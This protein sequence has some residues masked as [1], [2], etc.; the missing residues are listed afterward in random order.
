M[1]VLQFWRTGKDTNYVGL[2]HKRIVCCYEGIY[3]SIQPH[4]TGDLRELFNGGG[5][6]NDFTPLNCQSDNVHT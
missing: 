1:F 5:F 4:K 2:K 6:M 3:H